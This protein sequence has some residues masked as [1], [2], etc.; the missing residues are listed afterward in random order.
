MIR[1]FLRSSGLCVVLLVFRSAPAWSQ[2]VTGEFEG[3]VVDTNG[4]PLA[5]AVVTAEGPHLQ[6]A[7]IVQS[8]LRG[9]FR[10]VALAP[11]L[12]TV[13]LRLIG[14]RPV[15]LEHVTVALGRATSLG[16]V[17]LEPESVELPE[18]VVA[19]ARPVI[20]PTTTAVAT[21]LRAETFTPLPVDRNYRSLVA[22]APQANTS[23][24]GDE[25]NIAGSTGS[26][27]AYFV[28]GVD[29]TD[30]QEGATS[31]NLPYNF[32][33]EIQ[34]KTGGYEAEYGRAQGGIVN[35]VTPT[36]GNTFG[37]EVYAFLTNDELRSRARLGLKD[38]ALGEFSKYDV[39]V[40][41]GGPI[42]R[43]RVWFYAAYNPTFERRDASVSGSGPLRD[44]R[45]IHLLAGKLTW[46]AAPAT[47][48][49]FTML[50]DPS[51]HDPFVGSPEAGSIAN[52]EVVLGKLREGG[53]TLS[54]QARTLAR[55]HL[56]LSAS[57][58]RSTQVS[59]QGAG[60]ERGRQEPRLDDYQTGV[61]S[62]GYGGFSRS[63]RV[64]TA[65][66]ATASLELRPHDF[67]LGIE[68]EDNFSNSEACSNL[69]SRVD[70]SS[71]F[72]N[73][74]CLS[75]RAHN[76]IPTVYG[77]DSWQIS[78]RLRLN[79]GLRWEGQY[80][81]GTNG[82]PAQSI[83]DQLQPRAGV[84]YLPGELGT[85]RLLAS[86]GRFYEQV[87]VLLATAYYGQGEQI[88]IRYP[89][90]P[91][92]NTAGADTSVFPISGAPRVNGLHGQNFDEFTLGYERQIG[93]HFKAGARGIH[94]ALRWAIEDGVDSTGQRFVV[95]NLGLGELAHFPRARRKY[96]AL[97]LSL[98]RLGDAPFTFLMSYVLSRTWG[99]YTG[100]FASDVSQS[101]PNVTAQFDFVEQTPRGT[102]LLPN[103]RTHV[104]KFFGACRLASGLTAG[105]SLV[106]ESGTPL[107]EYGGIFAGPPYWS[108][109]RRRGTAGRMPA[110]WDLNFRFT[111]RVPVWRH[112]RA[113]PQVLL[114]L[115]HVGSP[116]R[117]VGFD[118]VHYTGIDS[119]GNQIGSNVNYGKVTQY[120]PPM[121]ARLGLVV[122]F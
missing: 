63:R 59:D 72:W 44:S 17:R 1:N 110:I 6:L 71:F 19:E 122:G 11:G 54:L 34:I 106:W 52:P 60:T 86:W 117:A 8:D 55:P 57:L 42:A 89:Q 22:L 65:A 27:N 120:Q 79:A 67:K 75:G 46:L 101:A 35:V 4:N 108:F 16:L 76:R 81:E 9:Y 78:R 41:V 20:D 92:V 93:G 103:D 13:R 102:G 40:G 70:V 99:N 100:L 104:L 24:L 116:R 39:G 83:T 66:Q 32:V 29:V 56:L 26:E 84:I 49:T 10:I 30:L 61:S 33:Q 53:V 14:R 48:V 118:Q 80:F 115:F 95:G 107:S 28:D 77:Q 25:T 2:D 94:R 85:Q 51:R 45:T 36:G 5:E 74:G 109:L 37:G 50:G 43:D 105:A 121:S 18:I 88:V 58:S 87:P 38:V 23:Y 90:N 111:Y 112:S 114:D 82:R 119:I 21:N 98:E 69:I 12:Y 62:G 3:W 31:V 64:R 7:R 73:P 97:E 68:Y 96:T 47:N 91:L 15:A 113:E